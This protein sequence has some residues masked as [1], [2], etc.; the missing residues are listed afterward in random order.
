M[1]IVCI[2][3]GDKYPDYYVDRLKAGCDRHI[4][5][6]EFWCMTD[7]RPDKP[8]HGV[9]YVGMNVPYSYWWSKVGLFR[10]GYW[11]GPCLYLDLDVVITGPIDPFFDAFRGD[12]T[13]LWTLDDFSYSLVN[14]K[15]NIGPDTQRLL[16]G[17]GTV[18]SSV[19]L[20]SDESLPAR[21]KV[22]DDFDEAA[23]TSELH[24]D[25]NW[26]TRCLW[27]EHIALLPSGVAGSYKY[28]GGRPFPITVFHGDPKPHDLSDGWIKEH[29]HD[30]NSDTALPSR[31][32]LA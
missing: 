20:W 11:M 26:I 4:P 7:R 6:D 3:W 17:V 16:G 25:Q 1:R 32:S 27:P 8:A 19:M 24:G 12:P 30:K 28:G 2:K 31:H 5:H 9:T 21:W 15:Q 18:N 23:V 13:K 22:Y 29:W 14:P 10:R